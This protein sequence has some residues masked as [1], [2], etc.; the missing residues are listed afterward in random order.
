MI[1]IGKQSVTDLAAIGGSIATIY[2]AYIAWI[3]PRFIPRSRDVQ[4]IEVLDKYFLLEL[5]GALIE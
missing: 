3:Y 2:N 1:V 5:V 4:A